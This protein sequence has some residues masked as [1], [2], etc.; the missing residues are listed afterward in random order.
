MR[1]RGDEAE[2]FRQVDQV[3]HKVTGKHM[4]DV[5][6]RPYVMQKMSDTFKEQQRMGTIMAWFAV[7][8]IMV[9]VLGLVA[10]STF[11]I[12]QCRREVAVR[13]VFGSTASQVQWR[14][15]RTFLSHTAIAFL[16]SAP[17]AWWL[18]EHWLMDYSYRIAAGPGVA[19]AGAVCLLT[20]LMAVIVQVRQAATENPA[21]H[22]KD[23]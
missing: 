20:S 9:S 1:V 21:L 8:A 22:I 12:Q 7:V 18:S 19:L 16:L 11:F 6:T 15:T 23:E 17:A 5:D 4:G 2:A 13:K 14:L 3:Y 10:M